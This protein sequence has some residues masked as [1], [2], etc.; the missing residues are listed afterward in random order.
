MKLCWDRGH[1]S[2]SMA[3]TPHYKSRAA[4]A[5]DDGGRHPRQAAHQTQQTTRHPYFH[6]FSSSSTLLLPPDTTTV[7]LAYPRTNT[8]APSSLH[9]HHVIRTVPTFLQQTRGRVN[10]AIPSQK[11]VSC[12]FEQPVD[13]LLLFS[14]PR[15]TAGTD[16]PNQ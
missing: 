7:Q 14:A 13:V 12:F 6:P 4:G 15:A 8:S 3:A 2:P 10:F 16:I 9:A 11:M 1:S 5:T